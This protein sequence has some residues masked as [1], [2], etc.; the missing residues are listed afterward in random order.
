MAILVGNDSGGMEYIQPIAPSN[1]VTG[2]TW[3]DTSVD[4]YSY[5]VYTSD[6]TWMVI[7]FLSQGVP[8]SNYGYLLGNSTIER[9]TFPFDS[10]T[11]ISVGTCNYVRL[12]P[13]GCNSSNYGYSLGGIDQISNSP[14]HRI[15][16][17]FDSGASTIVGNTSS[18]VYI[19]TACNCST[20]GYAIGGSAYIYKLIQDITFPFDSGSAGSIATLTNDSIEG[21]GYNSSTYGYSSGGFNPSISISVVERLLFPFSMSSTATHVGN[22]TSSKGRIGGCNSS[23]HGYIIGGEFTYAGTPITQID[24]VAF[25]FDS[26]TSSSVGN[27]SSIVSS[28][29]CCNSSTHGYSLG[30]YDTGSNTSVQRITF[31]FDSGTA[32]TVGTMCQSKSGPAGIDGSDFVSLF[33]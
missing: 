3:C 10:G 5:K 9:I 28:T 4:P 32:T 31:P 26:G 8:G 7:E 20:Y 12:N 17:P 14:I 19:N 25:P 24:R 23:N 33:A 11:S 22:L 30:G 18:T 15:T 21:A 1:P 2:M 13:G 16:F 27:L 29:G 6:S